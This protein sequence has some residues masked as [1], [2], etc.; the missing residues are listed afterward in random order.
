MTRRSVHS[1]PTPWIGV[2]TGVK[3]MIGGGGTRRVTAALAALAAS[4]AAGAG[5]RQGW[6]PSATATGHH[7][8]VALGD[9]WVSGPLIHNQV[10]TP[11]DCGRSDRNWPTLVAK[12]LDVASFTDASCGGADIDALT[13]PFEA[14]LGGIAPP[15]FDLLRPDTTLVT[16]GIGGNDADLNGSA[17]DCVNLLPVPLGPP[18][19]GRP[20][21]EGFTEGGVDRIAAKIAATRPRLAAAFDE[22]HRRAPNARVFATGYGSPL[23][24]SGDGCWPTAPML[25]VDVHYIR[26]RL[27]EFDQAIAEVAAAHDVTYVSLDAATTGHDICR[28][29][30]VAWFNAVS[31]DPPGFP[32]HPN[33]LF[34]AGVAPTIAASIVAAAGK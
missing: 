7:R 27:A 30:G 19:F 22:I 6:G 33:E 11:I 13:E 23:G 14:N 1:A 20:C 26:A 28:P 31:F 15:Q 9:S 29:S 12:A 4:A 32:G 25:A 34:H 24:G 8:Y 3:T 5:C 2:E 16:I 21:V 17:I 18:P 10:G